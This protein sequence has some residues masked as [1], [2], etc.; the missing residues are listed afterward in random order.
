MGKNFALVFLLLIV[1]STMSFL[2]AQS[3]PIAQKITYVR[4]AFHGDC[5]SVYVFDGADAGFDSLQHTFTFRV[6]GSYK[7]KYL[8]VMNVLFLLLRWI[9]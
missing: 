9:A 8:E 1:F 6:S 5:H 3:S 4:G 2:H 7:G